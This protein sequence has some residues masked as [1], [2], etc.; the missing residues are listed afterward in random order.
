MLVL[1]PITDSAISLLSDPSIQDVI[2]SFTSESRNRDIANDIKNNPI[3]NILP[4][5]DKYYT[6]TSCPS[7][8]YPNDNSK[9][10]VCIE[11][12]P[13]NEAPDADLRDYALGNIKGS[14]YDPA[15]LEIIWAN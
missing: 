4:I 12:I 10:A 2:E 13:T 14:G 6:A 8:Q 7:K 11:L 3:L 5:S 1:T 9:I 15:T